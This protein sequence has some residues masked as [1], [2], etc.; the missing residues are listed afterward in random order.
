MVG[1]TH[2]SRPSELAI[3]FIDA[4]KAAGFEIRIVQ[5]RGQVSALDF[6]LFIGDQ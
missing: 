4:L 3:K 1:M 6:D 5:C 2:P